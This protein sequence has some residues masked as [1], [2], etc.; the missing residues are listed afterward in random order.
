[1]RQLAS[2][3]ILVV[4]SVLG[5]AQAAPAP[6]VYLTIEKVSPTAHG[7]EVTVRVKNISARPIVLAQSGVAKPVLQS[8]DVAQWDDKLGWQSVSPCLDVPPSRTRTL[9]PQQDMQDIIPIG[10]LEHGWTSTVC[11]RK[12]QHL[13]GKLRATLCYYNSKREFEKRMNLQKP[14]TTVESVPFDLPK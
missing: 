13:Q 7:F 5:T 9:A 8:L 2:V 4:S 12:I 14:C 10:D 1:M 6:A 3:L 11:P